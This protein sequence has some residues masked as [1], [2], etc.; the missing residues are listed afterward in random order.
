MTEFIP[1]NE[2]EQILLDTREGR[3]EPSKLFEKLHASR[4]IVLLDKPIGVGARWPK[5][6]APLLLK[7]SGGEPVVAMFTASGRGEDWVRQSPDHRHGA[8]VSF[9][10]LVGGLSP[11][12]GAVLN[13]GSAMAVEMSAA[14]LA[15]LRAASR[16]LH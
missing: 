2:L 11:D 13:P 6:A 8:L 1:G 12:L 5:D 4:V 7:N 3:A 10:W 9:R 15:K 14:L 16:P